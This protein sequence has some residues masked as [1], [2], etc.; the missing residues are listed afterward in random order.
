MRE[1]EDGS[2][3]NH[4]HIALRNEDQFILRVTANKSLLKFLTKDLQ[5]GNSLKE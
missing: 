4:A 1:N 5:L 2:H 3:Q